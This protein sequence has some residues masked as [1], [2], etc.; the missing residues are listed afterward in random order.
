M[1]TMYTTSSVEI[2]KRIIEKYKLYYQYAY[3][4]IKIKYLIKLFT[5]TDILNKSPYNHTSTII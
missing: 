4:A 1:Y 2:E 3:N 5:L